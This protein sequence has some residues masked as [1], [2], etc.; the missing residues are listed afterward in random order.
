MLMGNNADKALIEELE[1][2]VVEIKGHADKSR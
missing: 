2:K 1:T